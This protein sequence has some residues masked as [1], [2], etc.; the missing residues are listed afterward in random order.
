MQLE[1]ALSK[2]KILIIDDKVEA[3]STLK[4]MLMSAGAINIH[5]AL[6][7]IEAMQKMAEHDYDIVFSDYDLGK[8]KDGQ[9]I[10]EEAKHIKLLHASSMFIMITSENAVDMVM[11]ALEYEPD[12]YITRP[13]TLKILRERIE[14]SLRAKLK[15]K[16]ISKALDEGNDEDAIAHCRQIIE[17]H[18]KSKIKIQVSRILGNLYLKNKLF[19]DAQSIYSELLAEYKISWAQLG[20]AV[21]LYYQ[22]HID[23]A[24]AQLRSTLD[25]HPLYVQCHDWLAQIYK[26]RNDSVKAQQELERAVQISPKVILRQMELGQLA[27]ANEDFQTAKNAFSH[28]IQLGKHSCYKSKQNYLDYVNSLIKD[29]PNIASSRDRKLQIDRANRA[30]NDFR[31]ESPEQHEALYDSAILEYKLALANNDESRKQKA[32]SYAKECY[33]KVDKPNRSQKSELAGVLIANHQHV[34]SRKL[35]L[36]LKQGELS[37]IDEIEVYELEKQLDPVVLRA[38]S[39]E[40]NERGVMLYKQKH[41]EQAIVVFNEALTF[42]DA[43]VSVMMNAIQTKLTY[44]ENHPEVSVKQAQECDAIFARIDQLS[45]T[46][47]RYERFKRLKDMQEEIKSTH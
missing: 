9:Q 22:G 33:E 24:E 39:S 2:K 1:N 10:L 6:D 28:S 36:E 26:G 43:S 32:L 19:D 20:L 13:F 29:L 8:G 27:F 17:D 45:S 12:D 14:Q 21:S 5:I 47:K 42:E 31:T 35:I 30:L 11:G 34:D 40:L 44:A 37:H 25:D 15:T 3:R 23:Q 41:Y 16:P 46:D 7:G 18:P 38:Y 4:R